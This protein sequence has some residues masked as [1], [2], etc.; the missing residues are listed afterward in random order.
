VAFLLANSTL[1]LVDITAV[2]NSENPPL[3]YKRD[4]KAY[5]DQI[6]E[7]LKENNERLTTTLFETLQSTTHRPLKHLGN[8]AAHEFSTQRDHCALCAANCFLKHLR[9]I[10]SE[11]AWQYSCTQELLVLLKTKERPIIVKC[12]HLGDKLHLGDKVGGPD[13][14]ISLFMVR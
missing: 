12:S 5:S 4:N 3:A 9:A 10:V 11:D 6:D 8:W 7:I 1:T 13:A 2:L 14:L